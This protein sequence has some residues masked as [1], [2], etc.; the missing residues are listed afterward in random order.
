MASRVRQLQAHQSTTGTENPRH[1]EECVP[2]I[3]HV[4][5]NEPA[6]DTVKRR[7]GKRQ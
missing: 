3:C 2:D 5:Q 4:S 6:D 1:L 7:V